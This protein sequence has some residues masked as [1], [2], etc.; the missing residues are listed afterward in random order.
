MIPDAL[1]PLSGEDGIRTTRRTL[2]QDEHAMEKGI[3]AKQDRKEE[4]GSKS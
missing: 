3:I 4:S 2:N 1:V